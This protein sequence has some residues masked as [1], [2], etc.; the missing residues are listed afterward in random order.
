MFDKVEDFEGRVVAVRERNGYNDSD[1][2]A[3]TAV[4]TEDGVKFEWKQYGTTRFPFMLQVG[5]NAT[6]E[7]EAE[8]AKQYEAARAKFEAECQEYEA[9]TV[10]KGKQ[11]TVVAGRKVPK[12]K[13]GE[14]RW[15]GVDKYAPA[16][17]GFKKYRVG[18]KF[19]GEQDLTFMS[20]DNVRVTGYEDFGTCDPD[21]NRA[22]GWVFAETWVRPRVPVAA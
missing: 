2:Y 19:E 1:F 3:L 14:V 10:A 13:Q 16:W 17:G 21:S 15:V 4:D 5:V 11:V 8:Y 6:A 12:G 7:V 18:V 9:A 22:T 20:M